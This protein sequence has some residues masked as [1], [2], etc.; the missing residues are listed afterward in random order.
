MKI[1]ITGVPGTGKTAV[2]TLV[3]ERLDL[4]HI[5]KEFFEG[6]EVGYDEKRGSK[7]ID[8][9]AASD[10]LNKMD[11]FVADTHLPLEIDGA[12]VFTLRCKPSGLRKRLKMRGWEKKK[13][14]ENVQAEIFNECAGGVLVGRRSTLQTG[15]R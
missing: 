5:G 12:R 9:E 10:K 7:V 11:G 6:F 14:D 3:A 15:I 4:N 8:Q 1:V 13:I 2:A